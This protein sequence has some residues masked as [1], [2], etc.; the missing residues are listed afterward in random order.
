MGKAAMMGLAVALIATATACGSGGGGGGAVGIV[1]NSGNPSLVASF[2]G[3]GTAPA[4]EMVRL[5]GTPGGDQVNLRVDVGA[6]V[7]GDVRSF[8][9]DLLLGDTGVLEYVDGSAAV[10]S[11]WSDPGS[12]TVQASQQG[13]RIVVGVARLGSGGAAFPGGEVIDL[14][15]RV[16]AS[17]ASTL[18]FAASPSPTALDGNAQPVAGVQFDSQSATVQGS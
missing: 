2:N 4:A 6:P 5:T 3:S 14:M 15:L 16:R 17:G 18:G 12:V 11:G 8:S 10:G 7:G 1:N 13:D 9:F